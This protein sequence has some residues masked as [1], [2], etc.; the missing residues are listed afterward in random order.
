MLMDLL[1][2]AVTVAMLGFV[3]SSMLAMGSGLTIRQIIEPLRNARLVLAAERARAGCRP[4]QRALGRYVRS[5]PQSGGNSPVKMAM[6]SG[7]MNGFGLRARIDNFTV[8]KQA[9]E[10]GFST[11]RALSSGGG[12]HRPLS[13]RSCLFPLT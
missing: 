3:V 4:A 8:G 11:H 5:R 12:P 6:R 2:K 9:R 7:I 1:N 10:K 13:A